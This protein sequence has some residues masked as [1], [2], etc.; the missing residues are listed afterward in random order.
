[1]ENL[2]EKADTSYLKQRLSAISFQLSAKLDSLVIPNAAF[3]LA[4]EES[5]S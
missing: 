1:M 5:Q 2:L 3:F 4:A